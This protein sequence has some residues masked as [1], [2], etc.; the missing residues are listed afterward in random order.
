MMRREMQARGAEARVGRALR[1]RLASLAGSGKPGSAAGAA[2]G[3]HQHHQ[4]VGRR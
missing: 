4:L 2:V 1:S 3:Y